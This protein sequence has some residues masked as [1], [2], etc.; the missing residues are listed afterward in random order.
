MAKK[1]NKPVIALCGTAGKGA[2][3]CSKNGIDAYFPILRRV[4]TLEQAMDR[5]I[6]YK[7]LADTAEQV[8]RAIRIFID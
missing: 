6:A 3:L 5:D 7:N 2:E 8:F 1:Y 4:S